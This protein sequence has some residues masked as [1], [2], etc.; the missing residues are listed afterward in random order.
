LWDEYET[1]NTKKLT[2]RVEYLERENQYLMLIEQILSLITEKMHD[3][4]S[5]LNTG[6]F[7]FTNMVKNHNSVTTMMHLQVV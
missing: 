6:L 2:C 3:D 1:G 7:S 4:F 5:H